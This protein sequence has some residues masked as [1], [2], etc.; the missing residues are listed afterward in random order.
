[1]ADG[2]G[3]DVK[4]AQGAGQANIHELSAQLPA[5]LSPLSTTLQNACTEAQFNSNPAGCPE[6]SAVGSATAVTPT[7]G[8]PLGDPPIWSPSA[9]RRSPTWCLRYRAKE[10]G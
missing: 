2:A 10:Y 5:A 8:A 4:I 7:L 9:V 3:L 1:M 6:A